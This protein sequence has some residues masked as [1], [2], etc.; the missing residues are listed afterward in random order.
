MNFKNIDYLD[1]CYFF[2][3]CNVIKFIPLSRRF[4][5]TCV[6]SDVDGNKYCVR[7]DKKVKE[8]ADLL[9]QP[10]SVKNLLHIKRNKT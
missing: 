8:S 6:I 1:N 5:L 10:I 3:N 9:A 7:D 2:N 4:L